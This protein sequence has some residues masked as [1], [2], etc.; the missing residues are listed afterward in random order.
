MDGGKIGSIY[1]D[2]GRIRTT[3]GSGPEDDRGKQRNIRRFNIDREGAEEDFKRAKAAKTTRQ[4]KLNWFIREQ[5]EAGTP[6]WAQGGEVTDPASAPANAPA[7]RKLMEYYEVDP[8]SAK[9]SGRRVHPSRGAAV[10]IT[11]D[12]SE[13]DSIKAAVALID[14]DATA[15]ANNRTFFRKLLDDGAAMRAEVRMPEE[16]DAGTAEKAVKQLKRCAKIIKRALIW[17]LSG[18]TQEKFDE[19]TTYIQKTADVGREAMRTLQQAAD[20]ARDVSYRAGLSPEVK[21]EI[22]ARN[23]AD[24]AGKAEEEGRAVHTA[25]LK[26][27]ATF[28]GDWVA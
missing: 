5:L 23:A 16:V 22:R 15:S 14:E 10:Q 11:R 12:K 4:T 8:V 17:D 3:H 18:D 6:D 7:D 20:N 25:L 27:F 19:L 24:A 21:L 26:D 9:D 1:F 28:W 2:D 13:I